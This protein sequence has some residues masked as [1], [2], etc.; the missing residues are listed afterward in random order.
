MLDKV[1]EEYKQHVVSM[2]G[3]V[4]THDD[5]IQNYYDKYW[6]EVLSN[7]GMMNEY[8]RKEMNKVIYDQACVEWEEKAEERKRKKGAEEEM[9]EPEYQ[10]FE[11]CTHEPTGQTFY[12]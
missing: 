5:V 4:G 11:E 10:Q 12:F 9:P 1:E 7:F 6:S 3:L 8:K 2:E